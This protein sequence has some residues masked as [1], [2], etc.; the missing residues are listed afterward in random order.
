MALV[1]LTY[2]GTCSKT[3]YVLFRVQNN[4]YKK[5]VKLTIYNT[6]LQFH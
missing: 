4:A 3:L 6:I 1:T 2:S 5:T